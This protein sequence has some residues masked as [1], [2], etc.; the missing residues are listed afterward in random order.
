MTVGTVTR[1]IQACL[2]R[3]HEDPRAHDELI[4]HAAQRLHVLARR[5]IDKSYGRV[6]DWAASG[7]VC[8]AAYLRLRPALQQVQVKTA[9]EFFGLAALKIRQELLDLIRQREGRNRDEAHRRPREFQESSQF[10]D[11]IPASGDEDL[12][13][14]TEFHEQVALLPPQLREVV[15]LHWYAGLS[16]AEAAECLQVDKRTVGRRWRSACVQLSRALHDWLP[17]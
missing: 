1:Q 8:Q 3:L 11:L 10:V 5:M 17:E 13:I 6:R 9:R 4:T 16:H 7:D 15:H 14:W 2:D 12:S